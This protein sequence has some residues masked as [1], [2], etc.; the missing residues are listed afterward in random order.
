MAT[1]AHP[2]PTPTLQPEHPSGLKY[3][4]KKLCFG[5]C[6]VL[7]LLLCGDSQCCSHFLLGSGAPGCLLFC[8]AGNLVQWS[9]T[10]T[11]G[12]DVG[13]PEG[14]QSSLNS[15]RVKRRNWVSLSGKGQKIPSPTGSYAGDICP[16]PRSIFSWWKGEAR[17]HRKGFCEASVSPT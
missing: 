1:H 14:N 11:F 13:C 17:R 15:H 12:T 16:T 6:L 2:L 10:S 5:V 7:P 9:L 3:M 8:P 4:S